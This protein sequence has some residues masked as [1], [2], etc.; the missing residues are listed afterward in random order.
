M[1]E[2]LFNT[3]VNASTTNDG[4]IRSNSDARTTYVTPRPEFAPSSKALPTANIVST[5]APD[6]LLAAHQ[7]RDT[8]RPGTFDPRKVYGGAPQAR[9]RTAASP[10]TF[11]E[12]TQDGALDSGPG[13]GANVVVL[14]AQPKQEG[15]T[16]PPSSE[17]G[18]ESASGAGGPPP[19]PS[20]GS[21]FTRANRAYVHAGAADGRTFSASGLDTSFTPAEGSVINVLA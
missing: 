6:V 11:K 7:V 9:S 1:D 16:R 13:P 4:A 10:S 12:V 17:T 19:Q 20:G 18:S 8:A 21:V 15:S 3:P 14:Y 5:V 2:I